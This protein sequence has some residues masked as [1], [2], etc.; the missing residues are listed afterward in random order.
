MSKKINSLFGFI[1]FLCFTQMGSATAQEQK[2]G[3]VYKAL[4]EGQSL[5]ADRRSDTKV[6]Y[7]Y[8]EWIKT[9]DSALIRKDVKTLSVLLHPNA[10]IG[11]SNGWV[12]G[13]EEVIRDLEQGLVQYMSIVPLDRIDTDEQGA[14]IRLRRKIRVSG[15]YKKEPFEMTLSVMEIW[16]KQEHGGMQLW[17]RQAVK[18]KD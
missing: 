7:G 9:L 3:G 4:P 15:L 1:L 2:T 16:I 18:I 11:H 12:Q 14:V 5:T 6:Q 13:K 17:S 8:A 10:S